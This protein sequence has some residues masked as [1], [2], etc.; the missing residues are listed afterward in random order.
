MELQKYKIFHFPTLAG[1]KFPLF[2]FSPPPN[3]VQM[4]LSAASEKW[5]A[6]SG[7]TPEVLRSL[8]LSFCSLPST[9]FIIALFIE[10]SVKRHRSPLKRTS[11]RFSRS[12]LKIKPHSRYLSDC[13]LSPHTLRQRI[14]PSQLHFPQDL[15]EGFR[16]A[17]PH[18]AGD[19]FGDLLVIR[20]IVGA[21][22]TYGLPADI[23]RAVAMRQLYTMRQPAHLITSAQ[24]RRF[25]CQ[26]VSRCRPICGQHSSIRWMKNRFGCCRSGNLRCT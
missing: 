22:Q 6:S 14:A 11:G 10:I 24:T 1:M 26:W 3:F 8:L 18:L 2:S 9:S 5:V 17:G 21:R 4:I 23:C 25:C 19:F 12:S 16:Q 7:R 15:A 13:G 20:G